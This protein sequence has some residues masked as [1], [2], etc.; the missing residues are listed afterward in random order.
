MPLLK[1]QFFPQI[2]FICRGSGGFD[3]EPLAMCPHRLGGY[4]IDFVARRGTWWHLPSKT[5]REIV[6]FFIFFCILVERCWPFCSQDLLETPGCPGCPWVP[7]GCLLGASL[8]AP[9]CLL[10]VSWVVP[11]S[12]DVSQMPPRC[13]SDASQ[14]IQFNSFQI[15]S[16]QIKSIQF[17]SNQIKSTKSIQ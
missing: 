17:Q 13:L 14:S 4:R 8:V 1:S 15:N 9:G 5:P 12:P 11:W 6:V 2:D 3:R 10:G 16:S 7:P